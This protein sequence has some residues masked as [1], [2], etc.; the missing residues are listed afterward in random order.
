MIFLASVEGEAMFLM[1]TEQDVADMRGGRTKF[2]DER[3]TTGVPF[4]KCILSLHK[5]QAEALKVIKES[6]QGHV[7]PKELVGPEPLP[8]VEAVCDGCKGVM[9]RPLLFAGKCAPCWRE[10]AE[11]Y[12]HLYLK[13]IGGGQ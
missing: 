5:N 12:R 8:T 4:K 2:V 7:I 13:E 6:G 11:H 1:L 3:T 9:S 10:T